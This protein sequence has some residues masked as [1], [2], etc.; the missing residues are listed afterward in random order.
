LGKIGKRGNAKNKENLIRQS[1]VYLLYLNNTDPFL[2]LIYLC[3]LLLL[4]YM[5]VEKENRNI[6]VPE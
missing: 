5:K 2:I 6:K 1:N 3:D 4:K